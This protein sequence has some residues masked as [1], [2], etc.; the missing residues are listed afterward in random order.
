MA[1]MV[2]P[3]TAKQ[4]MGMPPS[5]PPHSPHPLGIGMSLVEAVDILTAMSDA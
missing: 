3:Q 4:A 5:S 1:D 2:L